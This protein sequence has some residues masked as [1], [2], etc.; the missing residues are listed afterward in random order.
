MENMGII[1][2]WVQF[3]DNETRC[4]YWS[5][6]HKESKESNTMVHTGSTHRCRFNSGRFNLDGDLLAESERKPEAHREDEREG[7]LTHTTTHTAADHTE[8]GW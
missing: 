1:N 2:K 3:P 5:P 8:E 4:S 7:D 6:N